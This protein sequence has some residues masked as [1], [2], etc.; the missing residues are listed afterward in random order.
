ML[1]STQNVE[2]DPPIR[3][4]LE[5]IRAQLPP[6]VRLIA[7]T[8]QV[9][10][11]NMKLAYQS[12]VRDF[13]ES[14]VQELQLKVSVEGWSEVQ[15]HF[16]GQIQNNKARRVIQ[17]CS[18]IHSVDCWDL[19]ER[20][21]HLAAQEGLRPK[22]LLQVKLVP[23]ANKTGWSPEDL[24][25][26]LAALVALPHL[27]LR[28]LMTI[29]PLGLGSEATLELFRNL[30]GRAQSWQRQG[31]GQLTELSMGMSGD[32]PLAIEAGATM[33]RLGQVLFGSRTPT[34]STTDGQFL[35]SF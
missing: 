32:Y 6:G 4:N 26:R 31:Y 33:I 29:A 30:A 18:W 9:S 25:M 7:V 14:R 12:G 24:Q 1:E 3:H 22:I 2:S 11:A 28:G 8:K 17:L 21:N 23:D 5:Q 13:A 16:I 19:A 34:R 35:E 10:V 27:D 15:W 20:L